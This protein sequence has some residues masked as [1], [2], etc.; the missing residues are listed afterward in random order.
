MKKYLIAGA[1]FAVLSMIH[2]GVFDHLPK[3]ALAWLDSASE[4]GFD[5]KAANTAA[6]RTLAGLEEVRQALA[7]G[8][9]QAAARALVAARSHLQIPLTHGRAEELRDGKSVGGWYEDAMNTA[10]ASFATT[11]QAGPPAE[12]S[13]VDL[14]GLAELAATMKNPVVDAAVNACVATVQKAAGARS[15]VV[16]L[17]FSG[18]SGTFH[19]DLLNLLERRAGP[20]RSVLVVVGGGI[21][22]EA[23]PNLAGSAKITLSSHSPAYISEKEPWAISLAESA[24]LD[25][26]PDSRLAAGSNWK[27]PASVAHTEKLSDR[28]TFGDG[29]GEVDTTG[30]PVTRTEGPGTQHF[31]GSKEEF[32]AAWNRHFWA[33]FQPALEEKIPGL[34]IGAAVVRSGP[35]PAVQLLGVLEASPRTYEELRLRSAEGGALLVIQSKAEYRLA[36]YERRSAKF[37]AHTTLSG[38]LNGFTLA[39]GLLVGA[40]RSAPALSV[41]DLRT[42]AQ[43]RTIT[44]PEG[45]RPWRIF[46]NSTSAERILVLGHDAKNSLVLGRC[47]I[48]SGTFELLPSPTHDRPGADGTPSAQELLASAGECVECDPAC[49]KLT[50]P[51]GNLAY[52]VSREGTTW[53]VRRTGASPA[54]PKLPPRMI[55]ATPSHDGDL[56]AFTRD[57]GYFLVP[58]AGGE[59]APLLRHPVPEGSTQSAES[60]QGLF[61]DRA[62]GVLW[63]P[64]D[65]QFCWLAANEGAALLYSY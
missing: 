25:L 51:R 28:Y 6:D 27:T 17:D 13:V 60:L 12:I 3:K 59:L 52:V 38:D 5:R 39:G 11:M 29:K 47:E 36:T 65:R 58:G 44:L 62:G 10:A 1:I 30:R 54:A 20:G 64:E 45:V 26:K 7:R 63:F 23:L 42:G 35:G 32:V 31:A 9:T 53:A 55:A 33:R 40:L 49:T 14:T 4:S 48:A 56:W 34:G 21:R 43:V 19:E 41:R 2:F 37:L 22:I 18:V 8:R 50:I 16:S 61:R 46:A 15:A 57:D 24:Q